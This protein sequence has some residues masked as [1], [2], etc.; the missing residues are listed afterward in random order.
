MA[1]AFADTALG[2][3]LRLLRFSNVFSPV[4]DVLTGVALARVNTR[5]DPPGH[6]SPPLDMIKTAA[7]VAATLLIYHAGMI[8]NDVADRAEDTKT[9]PG[10]PI[11]SGRVGLKEAATLGSLFT[12]ASL[13]FAVAAGNFMVLAAIAATVLVYN[14]LAPRGSLLGAALLG[15]ARGLNV[16]GGVAAAA[17]ENSLPS[18][19]P[20]LAC[21][22]SQIYQI[23]IGYGVY[24]F[25]VSIFAIQEDRPFS[26]VRSAIAMVLG[27]GGVAAAYAASWGSILPICWIPWI[28]PLSIILGPP[29]PYDA[30]RIG[31]IVGASLRATLAFHAL[32]LMSLGA[33]ISAAFC[34]VGFVAARWMARYIPPN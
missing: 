22:A 10:R 30:Q 23:C 31:M 33:P 12:A 14:F 34:G 7:A 28:E 11:P 18:Y 15:L 3:R 16:F 25:G 13:G 19:P 24:I 8:F 26:R 27:A 21:D 17:C 29:R 20:A 4:A 6:P 9:R 1:G 2:A 32:L 5:L